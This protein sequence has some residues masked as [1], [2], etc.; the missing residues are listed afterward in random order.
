MRKSRRPISPTVLYARARFYSAVEIALVSLLFFA[1]ALR[2]S[3]AEL[4]P[5]DVSAKLS[6]AKAA[7]RRAAA[8]DVRYGRGLA[9][10]AALAGAYRAEPDSQI[11]CV[12]LSAL[13]IRFPEGSEA[14]LAEAL[15]SDAA[16]LVRTVAAQELAR[17]RGPA[18][19]AALAQAL[20]SDADPHVKQAAAFSLGSYAAPEALGA[21]LLAA[22]NADPKVRKHAGLG[23]LRQPQSPEVAQALD[24]LESD[25]DPDVRAKIAAWRSR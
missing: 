25:P 19:A 6:A 21:L 22:K 24:D 13:S 20:A 4:P 23:L 16:P 15:A 11:R 18:A 9:S 3:G 8:E 12:L 5:P 2:A 1:I 10:T 14:L 7:D 17:P